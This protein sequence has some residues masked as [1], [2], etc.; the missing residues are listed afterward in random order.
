MPITLTETFN[1]ESTAA[2]D[3]TFTDE[4]G[5]AVTPDTFKWSLT[6]AYAKNII[7]TRTNIAETPASTI[8]V[9]LTGDDFALTANANTDRLLTVEWTF[10]STLGNGLPMKE[11]YLF[12]VSNLKH[13]S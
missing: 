9:L 6:D 12:T 10:I 11:E 8:T 7:N 3:F 2:F 13:I 5:D 1:E 4:D